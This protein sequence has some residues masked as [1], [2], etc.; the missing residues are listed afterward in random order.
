MKPLSATLHDL[1]ELIKE[2]HKITSS[3]IEELKSGY[4]YLERYSSTLKDSEKVINHSYAVA[5]FIARWGFNYYVV[6]AALLHDVPLTNIS[7][8]SINDSTFSIL[9]GY[10]EIN[11]QLSQF[12]KE[13]HIEKT[14]YS[15]NYLKNPFPNSLYIK[16]AE[17][18]DLLE[19]NISIN[20]EEQLLL[21]Q[22]TREILIPQITHIKAYKLVDILENLCLRIENPTI[23]KNIVECSENVKEYNQHF[24]NHILTKMA[25][26][27]DTHSKI[28]SE[29]LLPKQRFLKDF[30]WST[31]ST[32]SI[33]RQLQRKA[34]L[35]QDFKNL[36]T[37]PNVAFYDLTLVIDDSIE[38]EEDLT[39][40]D[41]FI[42]YYQTHLLKENIFILNYCQT[43]NNAFKY[44]LL[45]DQMQNLYRIFIKT[46]TE[47]LHYLFG[48][49]IQTNNLDFYNPEE[50]LIKVFR[51]D[52]TA[53]MIEAGS[54]VLD[55]A[56][57]IHG[58]LGLHFD[59]AL[60]NN[61]TKF[62][63]AYTK[64]N[65]GDTIIIISNNNITAELQW[66]RY[67]KTNIATNH[68]IRYF[69]SKMKQLHGEIDL[70]QRNN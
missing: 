66:F 61:N 12:R 13:H 52:G 36:I 46:E 34:N 22:Q 65:P 40:T 62:Y 41:I 57:S 5:C 50:N 33:Y 49:I 10:K 19:Q 55:F 8:Q 43:T 47:Y 17:Q 63:P 67:I 37:K 30:F 4:E 56:F 35:S 14:K 11:E 51:K 54:S 48:D 69:T 2:N 29:N 64:L 70:L 1:I 28:I 42:E 20:L 68:L 7:N 44:L 31:R 6:L 26:I 60:L 45:C 3:E 16:I 25:Q 58:D 53:C 32:I 15:G 39:P 27:F 9:K 21:A 23:Y 59:H 18:I 24:Q 38:N